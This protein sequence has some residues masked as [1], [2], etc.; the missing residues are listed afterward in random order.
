MT[1]KTRQIDR[2]SDDFEA[3]TEVQPVLENQNSVKEQH[4]QI[5]MIDNGFQYN[6]HSDLLQIRETDNQYEQS[7]FAPNFDENGQ[8]E[9]ENGQIEPEND[10]L[11]PFAGNTYPAVVK[12]IEEQQKAN[13]VDL[14][15]NWKNNP[16]SEVVPSEKSF[17]FTSCKS[18]G[19][20]KASPMKAIQINDKTPLLVG[21]PEPSG[22]L[23]GQR[24]RA[25]I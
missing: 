19:L 15:N 14:L 21:L 20:L 23:H 9:P 13:T 2:K 22:V 18:R 24:P 6:N 5:K 16:T 17:S 3:E 7:Q 25:V 10:Q 1:Q 12:S 4:P 8:I 11:K